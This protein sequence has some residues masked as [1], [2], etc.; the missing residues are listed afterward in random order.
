MRKCLFRAV[1]ALLAS[2]WQRTSKLCASRM[3]YFLIV[4]L[5]FLLLHIIMSF[6]RDLNVSLI[7]TVILN[8]A[9]SV[10]VNMNSIH[11]HLIM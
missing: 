10:D 9:L 4:T 8:F 1:V 7:R 11:V 2:I 6:F 3:K 5:T